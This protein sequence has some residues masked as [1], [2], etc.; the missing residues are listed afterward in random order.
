MIH[1]V[2]EIDFVRPPGANPL[3]DEMQKDQRIVEKLGVHPK[4]IE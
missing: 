3:L 4:I 1:F 2:I